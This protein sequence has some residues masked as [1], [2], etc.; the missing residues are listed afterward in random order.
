M[1][2]I[3]IVVL[4]IG[5]SYGLPRLDDACC[6]QSSGDRCECNKVYSCHIPPTYFGSE[7][8]LP[9]CPNSEC[10]DNC[11]FSDWLISIICT[12]GVFFIDLLFIGTTWL[13][14]RRRCED[15]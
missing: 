10:N 11:V 4:L 15:S 2:G 13:I 5:V 6:F 7:Q 9:P 12:V 8:Y 3:I 14:C 1:N